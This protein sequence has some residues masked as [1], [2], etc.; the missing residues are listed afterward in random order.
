MLLL[1]RFLESNRILWNDRVGQISLAVTTL[2][3]GQG[4][5]QFIILLWAQVHLKMTLDKAMMLGIVAVVILGSIIAAKL[6]A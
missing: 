3:W 2:F 1:Q 4:T 6:I 5:L